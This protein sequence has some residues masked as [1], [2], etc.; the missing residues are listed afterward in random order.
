M[1]YNFS[2]QVW[3]QSDVYFLHHVCLLHIC[4]YAAHKCALFHYVNI[5]FY[6]SHLHPT[7]DQ[8]MQ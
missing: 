6:C 8:I 2:H 3:T 1:T 7:I 4:V 5:V